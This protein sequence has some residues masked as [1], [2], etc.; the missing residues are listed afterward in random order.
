MD[1][2]K[3]AK[4]LS[5]IR[6]LWVLVA[7]AI[8]FVLTCQQN[9]AHENPVRIKADLYQ[10]WQFQTGRSSPC[11]LI[12]QNNVSVFIL[13]IDL[14]T[15]LVVSSVINPLSDIQSNDQFQIVQSG[16]AW[17]G[18]ILKRGDRDG[19][20]FL[21]LDIDETVWPEL[22]SRMKANPGF[23]LADMAGTPIFASFANNSSSVMHEFLSCASRVGHRSYQ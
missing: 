16:V 23:F 19:T 21:L 13:S 6:C 11:M 3:P 12:A 20:P 14:A 1:R 2:N 9:L 7:F 22:A 8:C 5:R 18:R 15:N 4:R 17:H 10:P